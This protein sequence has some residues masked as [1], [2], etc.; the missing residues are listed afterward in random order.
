MSDVF[1][2]LSAPVELLRQLVGLLQPS[3]ELL[4]VTG[5][6]DTPAC[7]LDP[8]QFW[9]FRTVEHLCML[10]R[11]HAEFLAREL[12]VTLAEWREMS[13]Y[14]TPL[15][16]RLFQSA[17][18]FAYWQFHHGTLLSKTILPLVPMLNR[19]R[20]WPIAPAYTASA[21]H[22]LAVLKKK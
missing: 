21:D 9:Y 10:N 8:A 2:H 15:R 4:I 6:A 20:H 18:H 12:D 13:H 17:R 22:L 19:A 7:R 14:D 3:G 11:R 1:E 16:E 5:N